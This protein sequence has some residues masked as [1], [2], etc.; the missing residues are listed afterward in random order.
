M[1]GKHLAYRPDVD[2]L[3]A[4]AVLAVVIFHFNK[5]WLPGGF[6]GVD[7]FFVISG[8]LITGIISKQMVNGTFSFADFYLRRVKRIFPAALFVTL[9]S[10][11]I[12]AAFMLPE[13]VVALSKSAIAAV[14]SAAN[15]YFWKFLDT[16]YFAASS[17]TVPLLHLWSLGVEEQFYLIWPALLLVAYKLGGKSLAIGSAVVMAIA[18]FWYGESKIVPDPSFAYYMLPSRAGE[19]L[20][21]ALTYFICET[22]KQKKSQALASALASTGAAILACSLAFIKETDG[23]PGFIS[24]LPAAGAALLIASGVFGSTAVGKILSIRPMVAI[25]LVSFSLYLWHW[26]VL[27]FYRY[28]YGEP[29]SLSAVLVCAF[30]M[31]AM[32]MFSYFFVEKKFRS[33]SNLTAGLVAVPGTAL[34]ACAALLLVWSRGYIG[35]PEYYSYQAKLQAVN[36]R[37]KP[38]HQYD[39]NCQMPR[40]KNTVINEPRCIVGDKGKN[41]SIFIVGDSNAA[42]YVG[43]I[44]YVSEQSN[45]SARNLTHSACLPFKDISGKYVS[46]KRKTSCARYN[47]QI[48]KHMKSY[49]TVFVSAAW[50]NYVKGD[51]FYK[52]LE[53]QIEM[54][55][56]S[57]KNVVIGLQAPI[58]DDFDRKCEAKAIKTP[59]MDCHK[60]TSYASIG[61]TD[62]NNKIIE[63][64]K[65]YKNV[66]TFSVRDLICVNGVCSAYKDGQP[67]YFDRGHLSMP[68]STILGQKAVTLKMT[69]DFLLNKRKDMASNSE[70]L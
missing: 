7:I 38:A 58:F 52:V 53:S 46:A 68:G 4:L 12:G 56:K 41:P 42:H 36:D 27:A 45:I 6:V 60:K 11:V 14:I 28:A 5:E 69:P 54:M 40:F 64:A 59:F 34:V 22:F 9:C 30:F 66:S 37:T 31:T 65:K 63:I 49:D 2:G 8:F 23:F 44:K 32:T 48:W 15:I 51:D 25:G 39:Y 35:W 20:F 19:L 1:Q 10:V 16:S 17:D 70:S 47:A 21:G 61:E 62:S 33:T 26:P 18:T 43:F 24:A 3:R 55:S 67:L 29:T 13:D 57:A 50:A